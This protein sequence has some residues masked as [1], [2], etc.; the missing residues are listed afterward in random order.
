MSSG[1]AKDSKPYLGM[2]SVEVII[3]KGKRSS[4]RIC[5]GRSFVLMIVMLVALKS[6]VPSGIWQEIAH[7]L[8]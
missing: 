8:K 3:E 5:L 2:V 1:E 4:V 6:G 7:L